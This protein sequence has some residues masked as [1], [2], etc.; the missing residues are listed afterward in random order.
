MGDVVALDNDGVA[1]T[2]DFELQFGT[3]FDVANARHVAKVHFVPLSCL[4][5]EFDDVGTDDR[6]ADF[7]GTAIDGVAGYAGVVEDAGFATA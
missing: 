3:V 4:G 7:V 1:L 5:G 2:V 6:Y